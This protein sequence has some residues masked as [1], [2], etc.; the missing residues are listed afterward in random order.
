MKFVSIF[1]LFFTLTVEGMYAKSKAYSFCFLFLSEFIAV[2]VL[3]PNIKE[4]VELLFHCK[5]G[6]TSALSISWIMWLSKNSQ[7]TSFYLSLHSV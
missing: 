3:K 1:C 5:F 4:C 2:N 6:N 7:N